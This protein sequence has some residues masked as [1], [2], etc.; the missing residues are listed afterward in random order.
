MMASPSFS[1]LVTNFIQP[2]S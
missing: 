1:L 2:R